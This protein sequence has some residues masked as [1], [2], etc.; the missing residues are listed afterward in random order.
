MRFLCFKD[1]DKE[2]LGVLSL[3]GTLA[4]ELSSMKLSKDFSDMIDLVRNISDSDIKKIKD[5]L[6][7]NDLDT[8]VTYP[9]SNIKLLTPIKRPIHDII[10]VGVNYKAHLE[11]TKESF[12]KDSFAEPKKTVYFSKEPLKSWAKRIS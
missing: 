11:E 10:C 12:G 5:S 9:I 7:E 3:D 1:G 2:K 8:L 6:I 4:V